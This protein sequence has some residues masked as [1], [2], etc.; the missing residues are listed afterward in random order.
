[1]SGSATARAFEERANRAAGDLW[2]RYGPHR[3]RLTAA[4][5]AAARPG[6]RRVCLLGAGNAHD[7][8]LE[9]LATRFES[10]HLV[11]IDAAALRRARARQLPAVAA[12]LVLHGGVDLGGVADAGPSTP[13]DVERLIAPAVARIAAALPGGFDLVVSGCVLSQVSYGVVRRFGVRH[14]LRPFLENAL[15]AIHLR[16]LAALTSPGGRALLATDVVSSETWPLEPA[17]ESEDLRPLVERLVD[18]RRV[19]ACADLVFLR[20]LL[21]RDPALA[22]ALTARGLDDAWLWDGAGGVRYLVAALSLERVG[23]DGNL[24][25]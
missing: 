23:G 2:A 6:A 7:L 5:L 10:I 17:A 21:R 19:F 12:R 25:R 13:T 18:A 20:R 16:T 22:G 11:D 1:V 24:D 9:A 14:P 4:I 8:D 15:L 3:R